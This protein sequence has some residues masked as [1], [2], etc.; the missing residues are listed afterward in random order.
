MNITRF[1]QYSRAGWSN[2]GHIPR[3]QVKYSAVCRYISVFKTT[4]EPF[5]D[6]LCLVDYIRLVECNI[7][8]K[9]NPCSKRMDVLVCS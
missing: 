2:F 9:L 3:L 6:K 5:G 4:K 1:V 8:N 7:C